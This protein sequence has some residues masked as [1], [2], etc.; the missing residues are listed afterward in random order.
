MVSTRFLPAPAIR[1]LPGSMPTTS[2]LPSSWFFLVCLPQS[3]TCHEAWLL[4]PGEATLSFP[5]GC[6]W[7][8]LLANCFTCG[9]QRSCGGGPGLQSSRGDLA[10]YAHVF[11]AAESGLSSPSYWE[12]GEVRGGEGA[13]LIKHLLLLSVGYS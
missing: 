3:C 7:G 4:R 13:L 6:S 1:G 2:A 11:P 10:I 12:A 9:R 8:F 5:P